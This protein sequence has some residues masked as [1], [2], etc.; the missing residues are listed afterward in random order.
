M[1]IVLFDFETE[2]TN[3]NLARPWQ[4]AYLEA[5]VDCHMK[6][7]EDLYIDIPDLNVSKDAARITGFNWETYHRVKRP[8]SE[9]FDLIYNLFTNPEN[10][11]VGHNILG[12][13]VYIA[14]TLARF[15][16]KELPWDFLSRCVDTHCLARGL[17]YNSKPPRTQ[18]EFLLWSYKMLHTHKRGTKTSLGH[19][20]REY[21]IPFDSERLH[22]AQYDI[23][24]NLKLLSKIKYEMELDFS[25]WAS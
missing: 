8:A 2:S 15:L 11:L 1:N 7:I 12:F 9:V 10:I 16:G 24:V 22:D 23:S 17:A 21:E 4:F 13:D 3:L 18:P 20:C 5:D 25:S 6:K 14:R 19:L